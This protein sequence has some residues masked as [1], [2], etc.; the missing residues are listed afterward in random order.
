MPQQFTWAIS[1]CAE[2]GHKIIIIK[3]KSQNSQW[4]VEPD[5]NEIQQSQK[6]AWIRHRRQK[7]KGLY[8]GNHEKSL[9][10]V[11]SK[12]ITGDSSSKMFSYKLA[13]VFLNL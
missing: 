6:G 12:L 3:K 2:A 13:S 10:G 5:R 1:P 7:W 8:L 9:P 4:T 11:Q